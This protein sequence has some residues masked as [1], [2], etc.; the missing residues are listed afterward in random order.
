MVATRSRGGRSAKARAAALAALMA[1]SAFAME[2][3]AVTVEFV[4]TTFLEF[5]ACAN[6]CAPTFPT[7]AAA[8][9]PPAPPDVT[10]TMPANNPAEAVSTKAASCPVCPGTVFSYQP[11][12]VPYY[13]LTSSGDYASPTVS[14]VE[15]T[16]ATCH[17]T[18]IIC[19]P[20]KAAGMRFGQAKENGPYMTLAPA[21]PGEQATVGPPDFQADMTT[22]TLPNAQP[23]DPIV[24]LTPPGKDQSPICVVG[25]PDHLANPTVTLPGAE[26]D[27]PLMTLPPMVPGSRPLVVKGNA[28]NLRGQPPVAIAGGSVP[29]PTQVP[30]QHRGARHR[31]LSPS[32]RLPGP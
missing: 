6:L 30:S 25:N 28:E 10:L 13:T 16:C 29:V 7:L 12:D 23:G 9:G 8:L 20:T 26:P 31:R 2:D 24:T 11:T 1:P 27:A 18:V 14:T 22:L 19:E 15:P 3:D 32:G 17:G 5:G 4:V 21:H